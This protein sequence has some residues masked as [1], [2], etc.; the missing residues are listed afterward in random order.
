MRVRVLFFG[1]LKDIAGVSQEDV[2]LYE[3]ARV[4]D[5][6]ERYARRFPR[7]AEFR[8]SVA[9]SVN[10]EYAEWRSSL[11][12]GDEVAF[13]PPV[14]GGQQTAISD[15][16]I[17]LVREPIQPREIAR[18]LLAPHDLVDALDRRAVAV[19]GHPDRCRAVQLLELEVAIVEHVRQMAGRHARHAG[20]ERPVVEYGAH[21]LNIVTVLA[22]VGERYSMAPPIADF[23]RSPTV[24]TLAELVRGGAGMSTTVS[25]TLGSC[26]LGARLKWVSC[27]GS[28]V[29]KSY[30]LNRLQNTIRM[31]NL[32]LFIL[33]HL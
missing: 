11:A 2:E 23:L 26:S 22:E 30:L 20:N 29:K 31:S 7:L 33:A 1:Q 8:P 32:F 6:Y 3:G 28:S 19:S 4:E 24:A 21:S 5:L 9:A 17:L 27:S 12:A 18:D 15:D 25:G 13:L 16:I 14:S 10:Q